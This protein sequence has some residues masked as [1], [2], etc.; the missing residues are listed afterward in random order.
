MVLITAPS[1]ARILFCSE[2]A[3]YP[4]CAVAA[5]ILFTYHQKEKLLLF[6]PIFLLF[7]LSGPVNSYCI[8]LHAFVLCLSIFFFLIA[9]FVSVGNCSASFLV[10]L[11]FANFIL[12]FNTAMSVY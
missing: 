7:L 8:S 10:C 12:F 1:Q 11:G 4:H 9:C 2:T 5:S 3:M 6:S